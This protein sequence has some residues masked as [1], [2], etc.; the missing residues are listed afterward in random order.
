MTVYT[1]Q[2]EFGCHFHV[3]DASISL[4]HFLYPWRALRNNVAMNVAF[5]NMTY[6]ESIL[7]LFHDIYQI[8]GRYLWEEKI[9]ASFGVSDINSPK[10]FVKNSS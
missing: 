5:I 7:Y 9:H 6:N 2:A 1:L 4:P 10:Y 8:Y 3:S